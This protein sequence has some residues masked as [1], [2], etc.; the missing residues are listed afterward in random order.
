MTCQGWCGVGGS[1]AA[2]AAAIGSPQLYSNKV[3]PACLI[4]LL[5]VAIQVGSWV[6]GDGGGGVE[7]GH[8]LWEVAASRACLCCADL[9]KLAVNK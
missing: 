1:R 4:V 6:G 9:L 3:V 8:G 5:A 2:A 7:G